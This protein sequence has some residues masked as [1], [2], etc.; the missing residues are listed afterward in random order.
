MG[1]TF[2]EYLKTLR[3]RHAV[4][5]IEQGIT[6]VKNVAL[7]SGYRDPLYFSKVFRQSLGVSPSEFIEQK[8]G[9][10]R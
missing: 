7:L 10:P 3:L 6:S 5:L 4:F 2:S 9:E 8:T 1:T